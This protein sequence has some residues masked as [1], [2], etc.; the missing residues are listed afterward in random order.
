MSITS[1]VLSL[2]LGRL[3]LSSLKW[4]SAT[5]PSL[6]PSLN[7]GFPFLLSKICSPPFSPSSFTVLCL[8]DFFFFLSQ[9]PFQ[10]PTLR[11]YPFQLD[12][13]LFPYSF[14]R[15]SLPNHFV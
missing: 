6:D 14:V 3:S 10:Q 9:R 7:L 1:L 4:I 15:S 12:L 5:I 8:I 2:N 13:C 11:H